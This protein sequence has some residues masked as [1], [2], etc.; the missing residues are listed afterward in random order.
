MWKRL[1][2]A[3]FIG[4]LGYLFGAAVGMLLIGTISS[5]QHDKT[6]EMLM[7]GIFFTGPLLAVVA[8]VAGLIFGRRPA[9]PRT[10][11]DRP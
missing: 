4:F 3:L 8:F 5:N 11:P 9:P 7:T 10:P 2:W 1:A 6:L